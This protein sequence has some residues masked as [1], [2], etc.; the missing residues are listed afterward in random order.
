MHSSFLHINKIPTKQIVSIMLF[1][2]ALLF[3][4]TGKTQDIHFSQFFETPL[5]R[6]PSLAGIFTG[7]V[8][9]QSVHRSQ[10]NSVT[11]PYQ[12][13]S[14]NAETKL[15]IGNG[16]DF[17]TI[18]G[19]MMYDKAGSTDFK[20]VHVLPVINFHKSLSVEQNRYISLGFMGGYVNRTIDRSKI[21]T[22]NQWGS[23][24]FDPNL[25]NGETF[26]NGMYNYWDASVG[27]TYNSNIGESDAN[28]YYV[29][30]AFHHFTKPKVG[31]Y[32]NSKQVLPSKWVASL[33]LRYHFG[34]DSYITLQADHSKQGTYNE[35]IGGLLY[36]MNFVNG[37]KE[38]K[39]TLHAGAYL[40]WRDAF[41]PVIKLDYSP[42][43]I[44]FSYD[45]NISQ[46]KPASRGR[47]GYEVSISY[48]AFKDKYNSARDAVR[49]P[50]F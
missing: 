48:L 17:V 9:V 11:V 36:S 13:T 24:G 27:S 43:S 18:G 28:N 5:L 38:A 31:F 50:R 29:G 2:T 46:L 39:Y 19:Q 30:F 21:T 35:T 14:L 23:G 42:L 15:S 22:N 26:A 45:A 41:I 37:V 47:G 49:C 44:S 32:E 20:S 3:S 6:N 34:E 8:R 1:A 7:D 33:G 40:R 25:P 12:T 4:V 16:H 10:W